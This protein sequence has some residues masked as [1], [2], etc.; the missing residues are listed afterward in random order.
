ML[1]HFSGVWIESGDQLEL[2]G[3]EVYVNAAEWKPGTDLRSQ[4]EFICEKGSKGS[5]A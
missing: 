3:E 5:K 2:S 4:G 1:P